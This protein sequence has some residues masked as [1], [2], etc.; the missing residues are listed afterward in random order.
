MVDYL[1]SNADDL[2]EAVGIVAGG[3]VITAVFDPVEKG[4]DWLIDVIRGA[5]DSVVFLYIRGGDVGIS[6]I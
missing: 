4:F 2:F 1:E 6:G 3:G 5:E